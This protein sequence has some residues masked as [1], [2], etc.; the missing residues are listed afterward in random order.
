MVLPKIVDLTT[1]IILHICNFHPLV[2]LELIDLI[3]KLLNSVLHL[4]H[5]L[6]LFTAVFLPHIFNLLLECQN[7]F[8]ELILHKLLVAGSIHLHLSYHLLVLLL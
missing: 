8:P 5:Q 3:F 1:V 7:F 6:L 4:L 2:I